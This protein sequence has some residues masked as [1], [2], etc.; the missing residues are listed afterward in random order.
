MYEPVCTTHSGMTKPEKIE[1]FFFEKNDH[2]HREGLLKFFHDKGFDGWLSNYVEFVNCKIKHSEGARDNFD[3]RVGEWVVTNF[4][5]NPTEF[6]L[7][8]VVSAQELHEQFNI[9]A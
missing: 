2:N 5:S 8:L 6:F 4:L 1:A 3:V 7:K 9:T